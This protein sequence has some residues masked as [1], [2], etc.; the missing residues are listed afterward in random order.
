M[1]DPTTAAPASPASPS[2]SNP[3]TNA[4]TS[5]APPSHFDPI[6]D[7]DRALDSESSGEPS[8]YCSPVLASLDDKHRPRPLASVRDVSSLDVVHDGP[9]AEMLLRADEPDRLGSEIGRDADPAMRRPGN[10][11]VG[12][13]GKEGESGSQRSGQGKPSDAVAAPPAVPYS[14]RNGTVRGAVERVVKVIERAKG[15]TK[16]R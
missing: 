9:R 5:A 3:I 8:L 10:G 15:W 7:S 6:M 4:K 12:I 1:H 2:A 11:A 16:G 13:G 14:T